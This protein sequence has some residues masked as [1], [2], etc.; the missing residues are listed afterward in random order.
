MDGW[1]SVIN[2]E[3]DSAGGGGCREGFRAFEAARNRADLLY[4]GG[5]HTGRSGDLENL[6]FI[7]R[8]S[9]KTVTRV[10]TTQASAIHSIQ[11]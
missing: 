3:G 11:K 2:W 1:G 5:E 6:V 9:T 10:N 4:Q 7:P 8:P